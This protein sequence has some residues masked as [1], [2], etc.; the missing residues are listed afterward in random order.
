MGTDRKEA[1]DERRAGSG[2]ERGRTLFPYQTPRDAHPGLLS[3]PSPLTERLEQASLI[4][5]KITVIKGGNL[6]DFDN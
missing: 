5:V 3:D 4:E 1:W 6:G 2:T